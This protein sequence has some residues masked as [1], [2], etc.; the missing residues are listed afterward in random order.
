MD[1]KRVLRGDR[2][3]MSIALVPTTKEEDRMIT[4]QIAVDK[5]Y[6]FEGP[7]GR[8]SLAGLFDGRR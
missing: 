4:P 2:M 1:V 7:A 6:W 3:E 5:E 8:V